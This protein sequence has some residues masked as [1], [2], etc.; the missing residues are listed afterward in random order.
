MAAISTSERVA[1]PCLAVAA[2][3]EVL[4]QGA[5]TKERVVLAVAVLLLAA[6][7]QQGAER[8]RIIMMAVAAAMAAPVGRPEEQVISLAV[9]AEVVE[10]RPARRAMAGPEERAAAA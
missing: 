2:E 10:H 5:V 7:E 8:E 3:V 1:T 9:A 4:P 6:V